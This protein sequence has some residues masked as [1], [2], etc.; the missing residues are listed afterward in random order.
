MPASCCPRPAKATV[1]VGE[2][3]HEAH[4][5]CSCGCAGG[6]YGGCAGDSGSRTKN[7]SAGEEKG[8][9][10]VR[11]EDAGLVHKKWE[12]AIPMQMKELIERI[13]A[14][15]RAIEGLW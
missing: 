7:T 13:R 3:R 14:V 11:G 9:S 15:L 8:I 4:Y 5:A 6:N 1:L 2:Y 12:E 10:L